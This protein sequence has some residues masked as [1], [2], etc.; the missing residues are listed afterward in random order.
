MEKMAAG[1]SF[2]QR[3][4][5]K[6]GGIADKDSPLSLYSCLHLRY[7][8]DACQREKGEGMTMSK[9]DLNQ[10]M[11]EAVLGKAVKDLKANPQETLARWI[12]KD[13]IQP[14]QEAHQALMQKY[15]GLL[16]DEQ[17]AY[18]TMLVSVA[19]Q[20]EA[21][22]LRAL[23][24]NLYVAFGK[25]A[26][27][28]QAQGAKHG[29]HVPGLLSV[30]LEDHMDDTQLLSLTEQAM[31][32]GLSLFLLH[33][34]SEKDLAAL[35]PVFAARGQA[36]FVVSMPAHLCDVRLAES[37]RQYKHVIP[38]LVTGFHGVPTAFSFLRERGYLYISQF[39]YDTSS[40]ALLRSGDYLKTAEAQGATLAFLWPDI[41]V[42]DALGRRVHALA[43]EQRGQQRYA[44]LPVEV[45]RDYRALEELATG[46][47]VFLHVDGQG[48][49]RVAE[50]GFHPAKEN[51][52]DSS[53]LQVLQKIS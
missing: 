24:R 33:C 27:L 13:H 7:A 47:A 42:T 34:R 39:D 1:F 32:L 40:E 5:K 35:P 9:W 18:R 16:Q 53:F 8:N 23:T 38:A 36:V 21:E 31:Q 19:Q 45:A 49:R 6:S 46:H 4:D 30:D 25:G 37:W 15:K 41:S 17:G 29:V 20:V 10:L 44:V 50:D 2:A 14:K 48:Q 43:K 26:E 51:V 12:E 22:R 3:V 52:L 11:M 28:R